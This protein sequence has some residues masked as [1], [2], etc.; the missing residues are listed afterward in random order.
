MTN[1]RIRDHCLALPHVTEIVQWEEHLLFKV[2][3]KMFA[4]IALDGHSC[5]F[6]CT[7][8]KYQWVTTETLTALPEAEFRERLTE[9]YRIV[10]AR[11]SRKAQAELDA[12]AASPP[13]A[14]QSGRRSS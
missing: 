5:S 6:R 13:K 4:I 7:A 1:D 11:L 10:R 14:R 2:G 9:S 3:G 8:E 12:N